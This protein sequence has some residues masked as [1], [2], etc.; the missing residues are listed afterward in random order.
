V[1]TAIQSGA[2]A[3]N[4]VEVERLLPSQKGAVVRDLKTNQTFEV[5]AKTVV[6]CTG[7]FSDK[8]RHMATEGEGEVGCFV[9]HCN[10]YI[11][12]R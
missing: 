6:N 4:Y 2:T 10:T 3:A 8:I 11:L 5:R 9:L 1:L 12:V 7:P